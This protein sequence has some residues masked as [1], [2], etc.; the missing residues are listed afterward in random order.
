[1]K[2]KSVLKSLVSVGLAAALVLP[3]GSSALAAEGGELV[4]LRFFNDETWWPY[5]VWRKNTRRR[6]AK[7][8][9]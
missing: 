4:K 1:M 6:S 7:K 8:R 2:R 9:A 5:T 3:M